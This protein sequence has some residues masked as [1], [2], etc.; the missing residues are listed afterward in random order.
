MTRR[1]RISDVIGQLELDGV[2]QA[3]GHVLTPAQRQH[4]ENM[5]AARERQRAAGRLHHDVV[6]KFFEGAS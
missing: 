5:K 3:V 1:T 4:A 6:T 2:A